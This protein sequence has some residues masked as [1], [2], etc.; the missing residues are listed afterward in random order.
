MCLRFVAYYR[1]STSGQGRSGLGLDAQKH[2]VTSYVTSVQGAIIAEFSEVES[3]ATSFRPSLESALRKCRES[4]A[5]LIIAKLDRLARNVQFVAELIESGTEFLVADMPTANKF[6]LHIISAMAEYERDLVSARTRESLAAAKTRGVRLGN[7]KVVLVSPKGVE[8]NKEKARIF[9]ERLKPTI[10]A[11]R[12]SGNT[13]YRRM[14]AALQASAVRTQRGGQWTAAGVRNIV[15]RLDAQHPAGSSNSVGKV[16]S[17][18]NGNDSSKRTSRQD[19]DHSSR[20]A[21]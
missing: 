21:G 4:K 6:T 14:A 13:S 3:G 7:P 16:I 17:M 12:A 9:A 8:K 10:E 5:T 11:L 2:S 15:L 19:R 20:I 1:V 18:R